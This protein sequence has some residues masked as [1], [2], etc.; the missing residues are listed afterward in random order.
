MRLLGLHLC[1]VITGRKAVG[2]SAWAGDCSGNRLTGTE[3]GSLVTG[4]AFALIM[5]LIL[6]VHHTAVID[7]PAPPISF[8][9][10]Q[11]AIRFDYRVMTTPHTSARVQ[12]LVAVQGDGLQAV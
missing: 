10:D 9:N 1:P 8:T 2:A 5:R 3:F 7:A 11:H 4:F 12:A 6:Q